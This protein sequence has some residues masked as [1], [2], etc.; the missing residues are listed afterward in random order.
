MLLKIDYM[1]C[2]LVVKSIGKLSNVRIV[3]SKAAQSVMCIP[4]VLTTGPTYF[5]YISLTIS[6]PPDQCS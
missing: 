5:I 2:R 3:I 4:G 6:S 1:L